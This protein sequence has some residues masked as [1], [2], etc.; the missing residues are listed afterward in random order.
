MNEREREVGAVVPIHDEEEVAIRRYGNARGAEKA[1][2]RSGPVLHKSPTRVS[3][4][5]H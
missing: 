1:G 2:S 3:F 4:P 5:A